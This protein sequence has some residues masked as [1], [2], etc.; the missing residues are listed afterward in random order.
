MECS[1]KQQGS[2]VLQWND[3]G[4]EENQIKCDGEE[5]QDG[6]LRSWILWGTGRTTGFHSYTGA[7]RRIAGWQAHGNHVWGQVAFLTQYV[8]VC[9][10][11]LCRVC[12]SVK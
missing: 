11:E 6:V 9:G 8:F 2:L 7:P 4:K 3:P 1:N 10:V 5:R 12:T